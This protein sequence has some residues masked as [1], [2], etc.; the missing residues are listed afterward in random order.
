[1][2][3]LPICEIPMNDAQMLKYIYTTKKVYSKDDTIDE[4]I[5][6]LVG[7]DC[8]AVSVNDKEVLFNNYTNYILN[9]TQ[10]ESFSYKNWIQENIIREAIIENVHHSIL[11]AFYRS[12]V[13]NHL[14]IY[15]FGDNSWK[16]RVSFKASD[17]TFSVQGF[18]S[19]D[20]VTNY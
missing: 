10:Y 5:K 2:E 11:V 17:K 16:V 6:G 14:D 18:F 9:T 8:W 13:D 12:K 4:L 3:N 1:M 19:A 7:S 20:A 15:M